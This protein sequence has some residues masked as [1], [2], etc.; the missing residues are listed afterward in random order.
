MSTIIVAPQGFITVKLSADW[1]SNQ[2]VELLANGPVFKDKPSKRVV[3]DF[4]SPNVAK[5]MHVGHLRSTIIGESACRV[6]EFVGH[7]VRAAL[8]HH[9]FRLHMGEPVIFLESPLHF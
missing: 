2:I 3:V 9:D 4:S 7:E 8:K 1:I 5:E 6:L